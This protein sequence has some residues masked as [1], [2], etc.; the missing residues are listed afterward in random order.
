[1]IDSPPTVR[2]FATQG[3]AW[4]RERGRPNSG[5]GE[6]RFLRQMRSEASGVVEVGF[7]A[8]GMSQR[9][10]GFRAVLL[11]QNRG[12]AELPGATGWNADRRAECPPGEV[13]LEAQVGLRDLGIAPAVAIGGEI[14]RRPFARRSE[15][16][17]AIGLAA[18]FAEERFEARLGSTASGI[19][20]RLAGAPTPNQMFVVA[21]T[22]NAAECSTLTQTLNGGSEGGVAGCETRF[23]CIA[24]TVACLG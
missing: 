20:K 24:D 23:S 8:F 15:V 13:V 10:I 12:Q 4:R 3:L 1:M 21:V 5:T 16:P 18:G 7:V 2:K 6:Q 9:P 19:T 17:L 11:F 14:V 22:P